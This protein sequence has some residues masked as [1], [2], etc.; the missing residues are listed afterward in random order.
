MILLGFGTLR[1]CW[2]GLLVLAGPG[3]LGLTVILVAE[4]LLLFSAGVFNPVFAAYRMNHTADDHMAR[5][6]T[7]WSITAKCVQPAFVAL[8]GVLATATGVRVAIG[9]AALALLASSAL[10]PWRARD[11]GPTR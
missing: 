8:G 4:T 9:V 2:P 5:V 1:T 6:G 11:T 7:A 10:L 3:P